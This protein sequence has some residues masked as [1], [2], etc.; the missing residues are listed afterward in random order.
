MEIGYTTYV[1]SMWY[2]KLRVD[3]WRGQLCTGHIEV[4]G[5]LREVPCSC[6]HLVVGHGW[7]ELVATV[8]PD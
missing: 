5:L 3:G 6:H 4:T 7:Y 2:C 1:W 8:L